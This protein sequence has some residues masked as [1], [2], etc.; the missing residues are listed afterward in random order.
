MKILTYVI[1]IP[2][3]LLSPDSRGN[4]TQNAHI[5]ADDEGGTHSEEKALTSGGEDQNVNPSVVMCQAHKKMIC[6]HFCETCAVD[7]CIMCT[8]DGDHEYC[9]TR[10]NNKTVSK[11]IQ[12][13]QVRSHGMFAFEF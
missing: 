12:T 8:I 4:G 5:V 11:K 2:G 1:C 6:D 9:D 3:S 13:F 7:I 10:S